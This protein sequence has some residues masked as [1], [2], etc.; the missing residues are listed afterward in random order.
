LEK[1]VRNGKIRGLPILKEGGGPAKGE[2]AV[3]E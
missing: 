2:K 3:R 1:G